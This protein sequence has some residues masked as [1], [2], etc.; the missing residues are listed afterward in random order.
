[1]AEATPETPAAVVPAP[2]PPE[3]AS[4]SAEIVPSAPAAGAQPA[5]EVKPEVK[6]EPK[7]EPAKEPVKPEP[8]KSEDS[9]IASAPEPKKEPAKPEPKVEAKPGEEPKPAEAKTEPAP[10]AFTYEPYTV[11]EGTALD[12]TRVTELN[13][14]LTEFSGD[15]ESAR[16]LGQKL[17]DFY[18]ADVK[19]A[20][21][22]Q[23]KTWTDM[24]QKW[25]DEIRADPEIGG[26]RSETV[27][28]QIGAAIANFGGTPEEQKAIRTAFNVTGA[29]NHPSIVR[30]MSRM[31]EALSEA[32]PVPALKPATPPVSRAQRRYA[33]SNGAAQ[34]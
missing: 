2:V 6:V 13:S 27:L 11:P 17:V 24:Q 28:T 7:V 19:V 4:K 10:K 23:L 30:F 3:P 31:A 14:I 33:G 5:P 15:Q 12:E 25:K 26:N 22:A 32:S 16:K 20:Q 29:G 18:M 1:M 9:I 21:D 8:A 34:P